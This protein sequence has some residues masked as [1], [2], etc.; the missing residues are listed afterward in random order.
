MAI[1]SLLTDWQHRDYYLGALKGRLLATCPDTQL[2]DLSH[3]VDNFNISQAA[4]I[5]KNAYQHF[6][7]GSIHIIGIN[8]EETHEHPHVVIQYNNQY[9]IGADNGI[10]SLLVKGEP[11]QI[12]RIENINKEAKYDTF[13]ELNVFSKVAAHLVAKNDISDLGSELNELYRLVPIRA[14]IQKS[15]ITGQIIYIDSYGNATTNISR[16][17]FTSVRQERTFEIFAQSNHYRISQINDSYNETSDGECL[18][19]FNSSGLLELAINKG[20]LSELLQ[21]DI[22]SDIRI[23]FNDH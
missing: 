9:F 16:D 7:D 12:I 17:L 13:P 19:I 21:L 3:N 4:F 11:D 6:P 15:T 5:L 20:N 10:F 22:T 2:V 8:S 1:I 23:K 14:T 18:A